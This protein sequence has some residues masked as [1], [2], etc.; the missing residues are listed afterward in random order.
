M[1]LKKKSIILNLFESS[2]QS[3]SA[4]SESSQTNNIH[5]VARPSATPSPK[6]LK[7]NIPEKISA[8]SEHDEGL[9]DIADDVLLLDSN[10]IESDSL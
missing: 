9:S 2:T 5:A 7:S 8:S 3:H 10:H 1:Q 4:I 6:Q